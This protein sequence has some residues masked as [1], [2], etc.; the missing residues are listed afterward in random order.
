[1]LRNVRHTLHFVNKI[2][3]NVKYICQ[4]D[5]CLRNSVFAYV[6]EFNIKIIKTY[7]NN[8]QKNTVVNLTSV[9]L[10]YF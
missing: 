4:A 3:H 2:R 6:I 5:E 8:R 10:F 1:M 9:F 7:Q